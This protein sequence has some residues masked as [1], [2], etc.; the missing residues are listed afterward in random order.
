MSVD[1]IKIKVKLGNQHIINIIQNM[2]KN[3]IINSV[4]EMCKVMYTS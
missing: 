4:S 2:L 1:R 3:K